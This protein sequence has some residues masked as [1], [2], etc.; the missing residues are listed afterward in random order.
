MI[1]PARAAGLGRT[2]PAPAPGWPLFGGAP[3][4]NVVAPFAR[5]LPTEWGTQ[6]GEKNVKW[7]ANLG[8]RGY[9]PPAVAGGRLYV[10][11]NNGR[12]TS[13]SW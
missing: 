11:T 4:R 3:A 1:A 12:P 8:E 9:D 5:N 6:V 13:C 2:Q 10:A 7:V